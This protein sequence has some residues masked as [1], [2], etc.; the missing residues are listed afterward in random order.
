NSTQ[1]TR[2]YL[3]AITAGCCRLWP[4]S[5]QSVSE[6]RRI[7]IEQHLAAG[8]DR[9]TQRVDARQQPLEE[10][11][12][13][14]QFALVETVVFSS[15]QRDPGHASPHVGIGRITEG[16]QVLHR[17]GTHFVGV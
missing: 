10:E 2:R 17:G 15:S 6:L 4:T 8:A 1:A 13:G 5:A 3:E 16:V 14:G 9:F 7:H 11:P 12:G